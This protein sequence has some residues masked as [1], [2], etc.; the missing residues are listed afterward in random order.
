MVALSLTVPDCS[1]PQY[2]KYYIVTFV[3]SISWISIISSYMV[4]GA[5]EVLRGEH[6]TND[7][8]AENFYFL[9]SSRYGQ[10]QETS[11]ILAFRRDG[12]SRTSMTASVSD[13]DAQRQGLGRRE[14][15][16]DPLLASRPNDDTLQPT[17]AVYLSGD[18]PPNVPLVS[19]PT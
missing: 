15:H 5:E 1:R 11:Y 7:T 9:S 4:S 17:L 10:H 19:P 13:S 6:G 3:M 18:P 16:C 8:A 2:E 14:N 12:I